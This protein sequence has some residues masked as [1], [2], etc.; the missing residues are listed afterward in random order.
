MIGAK[1]SFPVPTNPPAFIVGGHLH[2]EELCS[3]VNM[4][5]LGSVEDQVENA[6]M[7]LSL[8]PCKMKTEPQSCELLFKHMFSPLKMRLETAHFVVS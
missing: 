6:M 2:C 1:S 7:F 4:M 5:A 3:F 8:S